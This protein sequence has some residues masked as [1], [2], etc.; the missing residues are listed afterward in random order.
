MTEQLNMAAVP[1]PS[2][3]ELRWGVWCIVCNM[4]EPSDSS[5]ACAIALADSGECHHKPTP[6][7]P[8]SELLRNMCRCPG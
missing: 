8:R 1:F 7:V 6:P 4:S 3:D 2:T 5:R